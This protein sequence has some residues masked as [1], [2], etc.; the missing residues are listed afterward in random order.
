V[1][2]LSNTPPLSKYTVFGGLSA[3]AVVVVRN[4][5]R[6]KDLRQSFKL[7]A[8]SETIMPWE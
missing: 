5:R 1:I 2:A 8:M 4:W 3:Y 7:Q 6:S